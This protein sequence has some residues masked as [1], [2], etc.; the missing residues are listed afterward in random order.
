MEPWMFWLGLFPIIFV[1]FVYFAEKFLKYAL[2]GWLISGYPLSDKINAIINAI[3][4]KQELPQ[5]SWQDFNFLSF[6]YSLFQT[7]DPYTKPWTFGLIMTVIWAGLIVF[8][9]TRIFKGSLFAYPLGLALSVALIG[10][11]MLISIPLFAILI[12]GIYVYIRKKTLGI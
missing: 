6:Y 12:V 10:D 8:L 5:F 11:W 1:V 9:C 2:F 7:T 4:T 3:I